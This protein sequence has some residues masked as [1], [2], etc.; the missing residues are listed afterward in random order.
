LGTSD[1]DGRPC[2]DKAFFH[3][4]GNFPVDRALKEVLTRGA[5]GIRH[6]RSDCLTGRNAGL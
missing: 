6:S 2:L 5:T 3:F 1:L 4:R